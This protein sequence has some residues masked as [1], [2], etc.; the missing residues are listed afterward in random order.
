MSRI[1]ATTSIDQST[2]KSNQV[3]PG[4]NDLDVD[5]FLGLM[6]AELQNQDPLNPMENSELV[7]Q[8]SQI[9]NISATSQLTDTLSSVLLGQNTATASSL[10][11]KRITAL[12]DNAEN[13]DG[14]VTRASVTVNDSDGK[15]TI[16]V[17]IGDKSVRLDNIRE[18][19]GEPEVGA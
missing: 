17:H 19:V 12:T 8:I 18:I 10:I 1:P 14:V 5:K 11:G 2:N 4:L 6:I 7:Q 9:R 13:V 15:H 3:G 16:R